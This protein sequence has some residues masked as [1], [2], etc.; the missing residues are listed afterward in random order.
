MSEEQPSLFP[1]EELHDKLKDDERDILQKMHCWVLAYDRVRNMCCLPKPKGS[2]LELWLLIDRFQK[3][4]V[5]NRDN[6]HFYDD[7]NRCYEEVCSVCLVI[8]CLVIT[9][10]FFWSRI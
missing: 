9:F 7:V 6:Q 10:V 3:L 1:F 5:K 4:S 2:A 8:V